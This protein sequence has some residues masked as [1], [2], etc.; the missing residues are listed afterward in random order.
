MKNKHFCILIVIWNQNLSQNQDIL[1]KMHLFGKE[2]YFYMNNVPSVKCVI[3]PRSTREDTH[4]VMKTRFCIVI[5]IWNQNFSEQTILL[6][7]P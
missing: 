5:V 7:T 3:V 6:K 2:E 4:D 1:L